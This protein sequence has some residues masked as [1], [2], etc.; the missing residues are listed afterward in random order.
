MGSTGTSIPCNTLWILPS[1]FYPLKLATSVHFASTPSS[2]GYTLKHQRVK[3]VGADTKC[4][5]GKRATVGVHVEAQWRATWFDRVRGTK[6]ASLAGDICHLSRRI[7]S[8]W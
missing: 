2:Y 4:K 5:N 6:C 8:S 3:D 7:L 1:G